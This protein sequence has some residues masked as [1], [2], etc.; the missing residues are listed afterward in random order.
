M[1]SRDTLNKYDVF[2]INYIFSDPHNLKIK[3]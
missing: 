3:W 2:N 1:C